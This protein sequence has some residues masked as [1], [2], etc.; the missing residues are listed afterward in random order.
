MWSYP[1]ASAGSVS[2]FI[3]YAS[4]D[5]V[6]WTK[7]D[8]VDSSEAVGGDAQTLEYAWPIVTGTPNQ[9]FRVTAKNWMSESMSP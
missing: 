2:E 3:I 5:L 9:F 8:T 1:Q 6:R 7:F 4:P